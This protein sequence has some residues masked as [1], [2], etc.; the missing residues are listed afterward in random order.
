MPQ[1]QQQ[2]QQQQ[3]KDGNTGPVNAMHG[4]TEENLLKVAI[5]MAS[6]MHGPQVRLAKIHLIRWDEV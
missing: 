3:T 4:M 1:Q 2:Q 5:S 6:K